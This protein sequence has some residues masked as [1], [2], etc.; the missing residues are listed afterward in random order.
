M[1]VRSAGPIVMEVLEE[2]LSRVW[3]MMIVDN[4]KMLSNFI[5]RLN[6]IKLP[7]QIIEFGIKRF[8]FKFQIKNIT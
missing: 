7:T 4:W 1:D 6:E 3:L 8:V 5:I 2:G